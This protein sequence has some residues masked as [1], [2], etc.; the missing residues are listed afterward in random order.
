MT[1]P[2][3]LK[4][5]L[6]V[7][8]QFYGDPFRHRA[9]AY[10]EALPAVTSRKWSFYRSADVKTRF[11]PRLSKKSR[12]FRILS[13]AKTRT[14]HSRPPLYRF[15]RPSTRS[16]PADIPTAMP[17]YYCNCQQALVIVS[18]SNADAYLLSPQP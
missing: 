17:S 16:R 7:P 1:R 11:M 9:N 6:P 2:Q 18:R 4:S 5:M 3:Q 8:N 15:Q 10:P 14:L 12:A 13:A